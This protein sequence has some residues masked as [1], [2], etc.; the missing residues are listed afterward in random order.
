MKKEVMVKV[1]CDWCGKEIECPE[2][3]MK[4]SKK[5]MCS[6]CFRDPEN[7]KSMK[8]TGIGNIYID[9]DL[10]DM[11]DFTA[12]DLARGMVEE[13]FPEVWHDKKNELRDLS[14][15]ELSQEMFGL[16]AFL[17]I[18]YFMDSINIINKEELTETDEDDKEQKNND[19]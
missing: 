6:E 4:T 16:G 9:A 11:L 15:K 1:K 5:Y 19:R 8:K 18:R 14:K 2:E 17:G 12:E 13:L 3:M 10:E 7:V